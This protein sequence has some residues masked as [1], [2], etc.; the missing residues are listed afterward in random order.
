MA[1]KVS[2]SVKTKAKVLQVAKSMKETTRRLVDD[3]FLKV[4]GLKVLER[5]QE[6]T[7]SLRQQRQSTK[8]AAVAKPKKKIAKKASKKKATK[9]KL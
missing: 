5:A 7:E 8:K 1:K 2:K 6:M 4:V 9:K 3:M